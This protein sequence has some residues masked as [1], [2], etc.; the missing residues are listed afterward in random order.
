MERYITTNVLASC[1]ETQRHEPRPRRDAGRIVVSTI[2][3]SMEM[4][5]TAMESSDS[6]REK[7]SPL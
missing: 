1:D 3:E 5:T 7:R 2:R 4:K 6:E